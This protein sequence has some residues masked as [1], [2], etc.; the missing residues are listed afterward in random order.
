L[1]SPWGEPQWWRAAAR[2]RRRR[3]WEVA[4]WNGRHR[5]YPLDRLAIR[6]A[7]TGLIDSLCRTAQR[8]LLHPY[9]SAKQHTG[10]WP[11]GL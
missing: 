3:L 7:C 8:P 6:A 4:H 5:G 10:C 11:F 9:L 1:L 2:E